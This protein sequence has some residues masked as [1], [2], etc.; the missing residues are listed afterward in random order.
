MAVNVQDTIEM[1]VVSNPP[2]FNCITL[3]P[4]MQQDKESFQSSRHISTMA[5]AFLY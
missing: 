5:T 2:T 1:T 4:C 3:L